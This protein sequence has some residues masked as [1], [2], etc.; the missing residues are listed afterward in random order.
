MKYVASSHFTAQILSLEKKYAKLSS[1]LEDFFEE[2]NS[3][4]AVNLWKW[5]FKFRMKN[6][7]IPT[8]KR[9]GYRIIIKILWNNV[10]PVSIYSK[11]QRENMFFDDIENAYQKIVEEIF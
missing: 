4:S 9:W 2:F 3:N 11:T 1:D 6:S 5:F 7:S 8:G 10:I